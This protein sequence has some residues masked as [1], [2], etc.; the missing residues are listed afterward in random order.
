MSAAG[1]YSD[2][3]AFVASLEIRRY[4]SA[5]RVCVLSQRGALW[6]FAVAASE[7]G[8]SG[9]LW[10]IEAATSEHGSS[11]PIWSLET[12]TSEHGSSGPIWSLETAT[13]EHGGSGALRPVAVATS[14]HGSSGALWPIEAATAQRRL[15]NSVNQA[16]PTFH[17][18]AFL[19][20]LCFREANRLL[21]KGGPRWAC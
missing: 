9:A 3:S 5:S 15:R 12:A 13:S 19:R 16:G 4:C 11:G 6:P 21:S 8:S 7:H 14:E 1:G 10:P 20:F 2:E 17:R 18:W